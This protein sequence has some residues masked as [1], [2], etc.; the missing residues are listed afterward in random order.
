MGLAR[1]YKLSLTFIALFIL[2]AAC[3]P[4][5]L[6]EAR[7]LVPIG[8]PRDDALQILSETSWYHQPCGSDVAVHDLFFF[9]SRKYDRAD[10]VIV[11]SRSVEGILIVRQLGSFEPYAWQTAYRDCIQRHMFED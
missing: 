10:V 3:G 5:P 4:S 11:E 7:E 2:I 6:E 8:T 1:T 9:G